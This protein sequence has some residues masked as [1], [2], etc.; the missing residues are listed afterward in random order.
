MGCLGG[1]ALRVSTEEARKKFGREAAEGFRSQDHWQPGA[2]RMA[3]SL[4]PQSVALGRSS[5]GPG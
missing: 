1:R 3:K 2:N 4:G 5:Q